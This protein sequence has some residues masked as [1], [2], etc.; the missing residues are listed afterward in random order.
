MFPV[1]GVTDVPVHSLPLGACAV[2]LRRCFVLRSVNSCYRREENF[3]HRRLFKS[4][5]AEPGWNLSKFN[6]SKEA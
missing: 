6:P 3:K 4:K 1:Y 2:V 5:Y